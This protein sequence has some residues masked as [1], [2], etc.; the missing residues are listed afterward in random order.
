MEVEQQAWSASVGVFD[1][2]ELVLLAIDV[3]AFHPEVLRQGGGVDQHR[4]LSHDR[5]A[6]QCLGES[7]QRLERIQPAI[8][9]L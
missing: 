8:Q 6:L 4:P 7:R 1:H 9:R 2:A 5:L 3:A